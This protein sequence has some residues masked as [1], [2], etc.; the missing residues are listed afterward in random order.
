MLAFSILL[1]PNPCFLRAYSIRPML[2]CPI[3]RKQWPIANA[4]QPVPS[5]FRS[6][7]SY[8]TNPILF[9]SEPESN[10]RLK[11]RFPSCRHFTFGHPVH[12]VSGYIRD[13]LPRANLSFNLRGTPGL[14]WPRVYPFFLNL[15]LEPIGSQ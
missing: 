2:V 5:L 15:F 12:H 6:G 10:Q 4:R 8:R 14:G 3:G 1:N 9:S 11:Q 13:G 7:Q